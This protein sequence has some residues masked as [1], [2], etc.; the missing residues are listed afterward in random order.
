MLQSNRSEIAA[1][2]TI[3]ENSSIPLATISINSDKESRQGIIDIVFTMDPNIMNW[4]ASSFWDGKIQKDE[5]NRNIMIPNA[6]YY[7]CSICNN[8]KPA[9]L[10]IPLLYRECQGT[11]ESPHQRC[12][13]IPIEWHPILSRTGVS[14]LIGQL[15][16]NINPNIQTG[17]FGK[18]SND[19][20]NNADL[21]AKFLR[22]SVKTAEAIV[23][24]LLANP[25]NYASEMLD[26]K[27][28]AILPRVFNVPFLTTIIIEIAMNLYA[29]YTK[30]KNMAAV[31]KILE[32][33]AYIEQAIMNR[34]ERSATEQAISQSNNALGGLFNLGKR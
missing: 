31:S 19:V 18:N 15:H 25:D 34:S 6:E 3:K 30:G 11:Q 26:D 28:Y 22:I 8:Q 7:R 5:E 10:N 23:A 24:S 4:I 20:K 33:R 13:T 27:S 21:D 32:N 12:S 14:F 1:P 16:A 29:S 9:V 2:T 17:N